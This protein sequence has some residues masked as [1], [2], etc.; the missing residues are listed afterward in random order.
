M[1]AFLMAVVVGLIL[2]VI[3]PYV[4]NLYDVSDQTRIWALKATRYN[5]ILI[6]LYSVNVA[7]YFTLR[8]GGD[9]KSTIY[10]DAGF[11]WVIMVPVALILGYFSNIDIALMFLLVKGTELPKVFYA[12]YLL[13]KKRWLQN[14]TVEVV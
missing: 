11:S 8:S 14:L 3:A 2:L 7:M 9:V 1:T 12:W 5:G 6:W 4:V 13:Q 10:A